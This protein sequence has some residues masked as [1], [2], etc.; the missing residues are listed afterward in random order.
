M[1]RAHV[2]NMLVAASQL[3]LVERPAGLE[4]VVPLPAL[5]VALMRFYAVMFTLFNRAGTAAMRAIA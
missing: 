2:R 4:G 5:P 1:S 3:G